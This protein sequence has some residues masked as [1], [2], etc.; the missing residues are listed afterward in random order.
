MGDTASIFLTDELP[1]QACDAVAALIVLDDGRYLLQQRDEIPGIWYPGFWGLFGG[2]VEPGED[3]LLALERE[4]KEELAWRPD[5][6]HYFS[7]LRFDLGGLG[8]GAYFRR[9]YTVTMP[10][11]HLPRLR[12]GEGRALRP[13]DGAVA[14]A[15][16]PI[17]PYDSF[18]LFLHLRAPRFRPPTL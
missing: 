3:P 1:L 17:V 4:L 12:L 13:V 5:S 11:A 2:G 18:A 16:L 14:L 6:I 9:F 15:T 7:D 10:A 8:R